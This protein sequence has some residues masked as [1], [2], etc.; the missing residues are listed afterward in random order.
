MKHSLA[1]YI[2]IIVVI[3]GCASY[4]P[5][6]KP[7][8][9]KELTTSESQNGMVAEV[10]ADAYVQA[11]RQKA[12]FDTDFNKV[13]VIPVQILVKNQG[14]RQ[15][16]VRPSDMKLVLAD[17]IQIGSAGNAEVM[18]KLE[19]GA[20]TFWM[21]FFLGIPGAIAATAA[22]ANARGSRQTDYQAKAFEDTMLA[23]GDSV[24]GFVFFIPPEGTPAFTQATMTLRCVDSER[25]T[26]V[27][28]SVPLT[29][30]A[31]RPI[32]EK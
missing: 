1:S 19:K 11:D 23:K 4:S 20:S 32:K 27:L 13:G 24:I 26:S 14:E 9:P 15:I 3:G 17:G 8:I 10:G 31:F 16:L 29:E 28:L 18:S 25:A 2:L 21:T 7:T 6:A 30:L 12:V 5:T 22:D